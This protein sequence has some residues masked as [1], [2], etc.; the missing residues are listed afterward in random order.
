MFQRID[1]CTCIQFPQLPYRPSPK[2]LPMPKLGAFFFERCADTSNSF[3]FCWDLGSLGKFVTNSVAKLNFV[4]TPIGHMTYTNGDRTEGLNREEWRCT[5]AKKIDPIIIGSM[6]A[7]YV[8]LHENHKNQL[9]VGKYT[10][11]GIPGSY[12]I[13]RYFAFQRW[14]NSP[15]TIWEYDWKPRDTDCGLKTSAIWQCF[16]CQASLKDDRDHLRNFWVGRHNFWSWW[17]VSKKMKNISQNQN[18]NLSLN[19]RWTLQKKNELPPPRTQL[20][21]EFI[22]QVTSFVVKVTWHAQGFD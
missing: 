16:D 10:I 15:I 21:P 8:Y 14:L 19:R 7:W 11:P 9:K 4:T 20:L 6:V 13:F 3:W 12:E 17:L 2:T 5:S 22:S 18:G 1:Q